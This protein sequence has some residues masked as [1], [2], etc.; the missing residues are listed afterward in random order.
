MPLHKIPPTI[1]FEAESLEEITMGKGIG[2]YA[3]AAAGFGLGRHKAAAELEKYI[4]DEGL[5]PSNPED[6]RK[7]KS[8]K[9][10]LAMQYKLPGALAG[11]VGGAALGNMFSGAKSGIKQ[12]IKASRAAAKAAR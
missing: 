7:I 11:Y 10:R 1:L 9:S 5:D 3:G 4:K 8:A 6:M 2:R 12:S